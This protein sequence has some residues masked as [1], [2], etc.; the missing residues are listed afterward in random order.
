MLTVKKA[1][2]DIIPSILILL[3][4]TVLGSMHAHKLVGPA[5]FA[6]QILL[7]SLESSNLLGVIVW[8][9]GYIV[10]IACIIASLL[11]LT[12]SKLKTRLVRR[13]YQKTEENA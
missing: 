12:G 7:V 5:Y 8:Y 1:I 11:R 13:S 10:A 9:G 4:Y 2:E 3:M 6:S